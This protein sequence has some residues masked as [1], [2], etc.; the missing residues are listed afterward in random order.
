MILSKIN[1]LLFLHPHD[2]DECDNKI[3][4]HCLNALPPSWIN[5]V[6]ELK[7]FRPES[8]LACFTSQSN[9]F[10]L[11]KSI[12]QYRPVLG[13]EV[14]NEVE[15]HAEIFECILIANEKY[16][17]QADV[18]E[19]STLSAIWKLELLQQSNIR[20]FNDLFGIIPLKFF[21]FFRFIEERFG[22]RYID[23]FTSEFGLSSHF[24]YL[25]NL[26][27]TLTSTVNDFEQA[28]E[29]KWALSLTSD[30]R[31]FLQ[32]FIFDVT[33]QEESNHQVDAMYL[34]GKPF[35]SC[36]FGT[37]VLDFH[38]F[39]HLVDVGLVFNFYRHTS[40]N[41]IPNL[42][43]YSDFQ[44]QLGKS[45]YEEFVVVQLMRNIFTHKHDAISTDR[46]DPFNPDILLIQNNDTAFVIEV[47]AS[48]IHPN[49]LEHS[50]GDKLKE[51]LDTNF[52]KE[53]MTV[54]EKSKGIYQLKNQLEHLKNWGSHFNVFPIIIYTEPVLDI[55]GVNYYL[56]DKLESILEPGKNH[57]RKIQP[58]TCINLDFFIRYYCE[59]KRDRNFLRDNIVRYH[60][61]TKSNRQSFAKSNAPFTFLKS[62]FS[63]ARTMEEI[64]PVNNVAAYFREL[65]TDLGFRDNTTRR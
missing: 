16:Y 46:D 25:L 39:N 19:I 45:F 51:F 41:L 62:N 14:A 13:A 47:K 56:Q 32:P 35:Y 11:A 20:R 4:T 40:L 27:S 22:K 37:M 28:G 3:F 44:G 53:K 17:K 48:R 65:S 36:R 42:K 63:F 24:N 2:V 58:L 15:M 34:V 10:L 21:L 9:L 60:K 55:S 38:F 23:E 49:V 18:P 52:A 8:F 5:R 12:S 64:F 61:R 1:V 6:N 29:P 26:M 54:K 31:K 57:F 43:K 59:L 30:Q 33:A 50:D 7:K